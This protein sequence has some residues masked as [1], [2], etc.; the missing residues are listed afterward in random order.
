MKIVIPS[1]NRIEILKNKTFKTLME[2]GIGLEQIYVFVAN[3]DQYEIYKQGLPENT[4][5]IIGILGMCNIRNFIRDYFEEGEILYH[6]DDD[7]DRFVFRNGKNINSIMTDCEEYLKTNPLA[8]IGF[9]PHHNEFYIKQNGITSGNYF[10]VGSMFIVKND[11]SITI[12][13]DVVEDKYRSLEYYHK[14]GMVGRCWDL[15]YRY[16]QFTAGGVNDANGRNYEKYYSQHAIVYYQYF[17]YILLTEKKIKYIS[18]EPIPHFRWRMLKKKP[19]IILP[20]VLVMP[21]IQKSLF[22]P[23]LELLGKINL[24]KRA[25]EEQA[26]TE[27]SV[28]SFRKGFPEHRAEV[29]GLVKLRPVNGGGLAISKASERRKEI[30]EEIKRIGDLIVPFKYTSILVNNNCVCGSH[31]DKNNVGRSLIVSIGEYEGCK[32]VIGEKEYDAKYQPLIFNGAEHEHRNTDDLT[33][34]KYS[35]VFYNL[36]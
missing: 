34:N 5:I 30:Y 2:N 17:P 22:A 6:M 16:E 13:Y 19:E 9:P 14:Y 7:L 18:K 4:N 31:K 36:E 26:K 23:L 33:G 11:K 27:T 8:L 21:K 29:Y 24:D 3:Q 35:L 20:S 28:G 10:C 1:Y 25:S 15:L 12:K 32:L